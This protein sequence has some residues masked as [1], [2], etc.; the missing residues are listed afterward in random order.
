M[1]DTGIPSILKLLKCGCKTCVTACLIILVEHADKF[2]LDD[3]VKLGELHV[4]LSNKPDKINIPHE[5][6]QTDDHT[7]ILTVPPGTNVKYT[8]MKEGSDLA[9]A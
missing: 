4:S 8:T 9:D 7:L 2:D 5:L 1:L 6:V 3:L